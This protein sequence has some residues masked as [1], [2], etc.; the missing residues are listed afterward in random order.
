MVVEGNH[1]EKIDLAP[2]RKHLRT[3]L[4]KFDVGSLTHEEIEKKT[5]D[6]YENKH[7][8]SSQKLLN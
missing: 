3:S 7:F 1:M 4:T 8:E 6:L 5:W 2:R